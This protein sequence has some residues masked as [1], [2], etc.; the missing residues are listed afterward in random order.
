[1]LTFAAILVARLLDPLSI[2]L[3]MLAAW[4]MPRLWQSM[5][6]GAAA[7]VALMLAMG[8]PTTP[9]VFAATATAGA[10]IGLAA[11]RLRAWLSARKAAKA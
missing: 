4:W 2:G 3:C 6:A 11:N 10:L 5:A 7:Y 8:N 1:M 9:V